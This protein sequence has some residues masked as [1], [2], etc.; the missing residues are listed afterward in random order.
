MNYMENKLRDSFGDFLRELNLFGNG[1]EIGVAEGNYSEKLIKNTELKKIYLLDAWKDFDQKSE[2]LS[3]FQKVQ[4]KM[5]LGVV[6][7]MKKYN[8]RVEIIRGDTREV[9]K[10]FSDGFFD[11][12]YIDSNH[13]YEFVKLDLNNWYPKLKVGGVFSGHDYLDGFFPELGNNA[14]FGVKKAVDEFCKHINKDVLLTR[15]TKKYPVSWYFIK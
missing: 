11:F 15:G 3:Q 14:N 5:Y 2:S 6:D 8:D 13:E 7:R 12:I 1:I 9:F 4:N 10:K